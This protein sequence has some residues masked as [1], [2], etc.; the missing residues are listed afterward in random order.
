MEHWKAWEREDSP[1]YL[2]ACDF[3]AVFMTRYERRNMMALMKN[4][5]PYL[6]N[7]TIFCTCETVIF[8][9][10]GATGLSLIELHTN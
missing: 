10:E 1:A 3:G 7:I 2:V 8:I 4:K 5:I 6:T 9:I